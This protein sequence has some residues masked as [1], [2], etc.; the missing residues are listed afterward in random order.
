[1]LA[2]TPDFV[3]EDSVTGKSVGRDAFGDLVLNSADFRAASRHMALNIAV[4]GD[5]EERAVS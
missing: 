3:L 2:V 1:V 5:G 4:S